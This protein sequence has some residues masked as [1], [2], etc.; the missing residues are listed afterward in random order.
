M[1]SIGY[2]LGFRLDTQLS[3]SEST[4]PVPF[5]TSQSTGVLR[6]N[7]SGFVGFQFTVGASPIT[8]T[9]LGRLVFAGNT[10]TH[11]VN[12]YDNGGSGIPILTVTVATLGQTAGQYTYANVITPMVLAAGGI[13]FC[14]SQ[15]LSAGDQWADQTTT[16]VGASVAT[17]NGSAIILSTAPQLG[18]AGLFS[19]VPP[20][21]LYHL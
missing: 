2:G 3:P 13:Y 21:F 8:I 10:F 5:I 20:N 6:N 12:L 15:E 7:F 16:V 17:V 9:A 4:A 18:A 19:Y 11:V 1:P 14:L